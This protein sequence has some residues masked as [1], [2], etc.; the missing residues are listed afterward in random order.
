VQ[1]QLIKMAAAA[2]GITTETT[3]QVIGEVMTFVQTANARI[4][5]LEL[6]STEIYNMMRDLHMIEYPDKYPA[7]LEVI[8]HGG[9]AA[10][11]S[12]TGRVAVVD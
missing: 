3:Q 11:S 5:A 1:E 12:D 6:Q 8:S 2:F 10:D 4:G 7:V 9:T